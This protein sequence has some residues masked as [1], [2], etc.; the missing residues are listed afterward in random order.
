MRA[1]ELEHFDLPLCD[2][3]ACLCVCVCVCAR[4]CLC[5]RAGTYSRCVSVMVVRISV[6]LVFKISFEHVSCT[7]C[8][9][10]TR[11]PVFWKINCI[12]QNH[13]L[14]SPAPLSNQCCVWFRCGFPFLQESTF[15]FVARE[16]SPE[17]GETT[18]IGRGRGG[19]RALIYN[20]PLYFRKHRTENSFMNRSLLQG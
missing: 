19:R 9:T 18:L 17:Q 1:G 13:C 2:P 8:C 7:Q 11:V 5:G 4:G 16:H 6:C 12:L 20:N 3:R 14:P 10:F 15:S